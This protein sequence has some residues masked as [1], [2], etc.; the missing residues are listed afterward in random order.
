[1]PIKLQSSVRKVW[2]AQIDA[3]EGDVEDRK[4]KQELTLEVIV[5]WSRFNHTTKK[6]TENITSS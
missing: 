6:L 2:E 1:M 5:L 4:R 3:Q